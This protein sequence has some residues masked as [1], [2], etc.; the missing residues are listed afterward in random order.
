MSNLCAIYEYKTFPGQSMKTGYY[1]VNTMKHD[2]N[3][4]S[5]NAYWDTVKKDGQV[6]ICYEETVRTITFHAG[7]SS[8]D[9][10]IPWSYIREKDGIETTV[11]LPTNKETKLP[12]NDEWIIPLIAHSS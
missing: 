5:C 10:T 9:K 12:K 11:D 1:L 2:V 7:L 3:S 4:P 6:L 8:T